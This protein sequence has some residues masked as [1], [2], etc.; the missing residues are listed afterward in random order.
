[1]GTF[2]TRLQKD[3]CLVSPVAITLSDL[4][5]TM[6]DAL[7]PSSVVV[8]WP[9]VLLA[10]AEVK[11]LRRGR[12]VNCGEIEIGIVFYLTECEMI[13]EKLHAVDADIE[14]TRCT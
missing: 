13:N 2:T 3:W 12:N 10:N 1:M 6:P 11:E 7:W 8:L 14:S 4:L 9:K 5:Y